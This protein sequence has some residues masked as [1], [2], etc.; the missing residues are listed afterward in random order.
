MSKGVSKE[1][2]KRE[3]QGVSEGG[4]ERGFKGMPQGGAL[5]KLQ[6]RV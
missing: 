3:S 4:P 5:G 1:G 2:S 6:G